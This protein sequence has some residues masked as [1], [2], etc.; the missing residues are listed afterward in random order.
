[1]DALGPL[2]TR[3]AA[4]YNKPVVVSVNSGNRYQGFVKILE[5]GGLPVYG[6]IRSAMRALETFCTHQLQG[7]L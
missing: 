4:K 3:T 2:L 6:D 7:V 5:E 1:M